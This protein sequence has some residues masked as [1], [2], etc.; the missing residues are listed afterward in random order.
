VRHFSAALKGGS[1]LP[2][3]EGGVKHLRAPA[4][5]AGERH[6]MV[7]STRLFLKCPEVRGR[8]HPNLLYAPKVKQVFVPGH[9]TF[10][11]PG[12]G[13][14]YDLIVIGIPAD[15]FGKLQRCYYFK[16]RFKQMDS[17]F[18]FMRGKPELMYEFPL[19]LPENER[20][21][22]YFMVERTMLDQFIT[23]AMRYK[24]C[25]KHIGVQDNLHDTRSKT[26]WSV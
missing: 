9:D 6:A 8:N 3:S 1:E 25:N 22:H 14:S 23:G 24:G 19:E 21:K 12:K 26:S 16:S 7:R 2:H 11:V 5:A 15:G 13:G 10:T 4:A 18:R 17:T 20:G